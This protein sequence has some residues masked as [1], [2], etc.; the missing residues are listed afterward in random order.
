MPDN[1]DASGSRHHTARG[2]TDSRAARVAQ[3][4]RYGWGVL[5]YN[6]LVILWGAYVRATWSCAG[7]ELTHR[8]AS[9]LA[10]AAVVLLMFWARRLFA[11][12]S[13]TRRAAHLAMVLMVTAALVGAGLVLFERITDNDALAR[14]CW[15][16]AHLFTTFL[17]IAALALVPWFASGHRAPKIRGGGRSVTMLGLSLAGILLLSMTG[18]VITLGDS[19]LPAAMAEGLAQD[20]SPTALWLPR[21]RVI[22]PILAV[23][24][25]GLILLTAGV[26][27]RDHP[28]RTTQD[29]GLGLAVLVAAQMIA[30]LMNVMLMAPVWMQIFH[31]LLAD[32]IWLTVVL[33]GAAALG[34]TGGRQ[35][36]AD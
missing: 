7:C 17:L 26:V 35:Q 27:S 15:L 12:G 19:L 28:S 4:T 29:L 10:L 30:G 14:A 32:G 1:Q 36:R 34:T 33:F 6:L 22:H 23:L 16:A 13:T 8:T 25:G 3:F 2:T 20:P 18:A 9:G 31:L 24:V 21:M 5:G 11:P